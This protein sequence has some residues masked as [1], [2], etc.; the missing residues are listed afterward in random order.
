[1]YGALEAAKAKWDRGLEDFQ[2]LKLDCGRFLKRD[3]YRSS[4]EFEAES[5][6]YVAYSRM[7]EKA[8]PD[9]SVLV[10]S[11]AYQCLSALNVIAWELA[12]RKTGRRKILQKH[13]QRDISFPIAVRPQDFESLR[14]FT[15]SYVG[16]KATAGLR[17]VQPYKTRHGP[18]GPGQ[19]P[20]FMIKAFAD[21]DKHRVLAPMLGQSVLEDVRFVWDEAVASNPRVQHWTSRR[22]IGGVPV[23]GDGT[24]LSRIRFEVG[25]A[26]AKVRVNRKP[27]VKVKFATEGWVVGLDDVAQGL[28]TTMRTVRDLAPLF[29]R[30]TDPWLDDPRFSG[31]SHA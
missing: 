9:F 21:S 29:P 30:E 6:W 19:H 17:G 8:P 5:G 18:G 11:I 4:V 28:G 26:K 22:R 7:V 27:A 16:K 24:P 1:M 14:L 20:L 3:P 12:A 10:G 31:A 15:Q 23:I 13:I 25:N 2:G